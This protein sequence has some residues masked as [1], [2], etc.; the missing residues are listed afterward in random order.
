MRLVQFGIVW[1]GKE[2][3]SVEVYQDIKNRFGSK[4]VSQDVSQVVTLFHP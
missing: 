2:F 3:K 1:S 4:Y